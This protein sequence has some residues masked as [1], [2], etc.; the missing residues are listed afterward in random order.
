[1]RTVIDGAFAAGG[2]AQRYNNIV[3]SVSIQRSLKSSS[4]T[5][6]FTQ[7]I[8]RPYID[9]LNPF[10]DRSNP[11]Y[12]NVGNPNLR[13]TTNNNFELGYSNCTKGSININTNYSFSNNSIENVTSYLGGNV[14]GTT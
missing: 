1:E 5:F 12:V 4:L 6:G 10:V 11:Q 2:I 8:Q 7:R 13:P 14:T 3:P 9:Q